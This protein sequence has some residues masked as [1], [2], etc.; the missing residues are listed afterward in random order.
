MSDRVA[1]FNDGII[2]QLATPEVLY[3][4]PE[5]A[6]VAQFI[7]ENNKL[8]GKI[9]SQ[10]DNGLCEVELAGN[11]VVS[12]LNVQGREIGAET[13]MSIRPERVILNPQENQVDNSASGKIVESIYL[14]DHLRLNVQAFGEQEFIMK[15]PNATEHSSLVEGTD[16]SVGW[17]SEDCR[18]LDPFVPI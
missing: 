14:G 17:R 11:Q 9:K 10:M 3:E 2:Q 5:N 18:A 13:S 7:G 6:F 8:E 4:E 1:V 15:V 12:A 16:V